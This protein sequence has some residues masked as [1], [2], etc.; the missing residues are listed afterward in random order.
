MSGALY[1][2]SSS[3]GK[4]VVKNL[5]D[6]NVRVTADVTILA[7]H[8]GN[9]G[10]IFR[11]SSAS[12]GADSYNGYYAGIGADGY[13]VLGRADQ[14]W[15]ELKRVSV[16]IAALKAHRISVDAIG[17]QISVTVDNADKPQIQV[18]DGTFA[19]GSAGVRLFNIDTEYGN[20]S[21]APVVAFRRATSTAGYRTVR[22]MSPSRCSRTPALMT[23]RTRPT[24]L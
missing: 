8:E 3:G 11:V 18:R 10:V 21:V 22:A 6:S 1:G 9:A 19:S 17:D 13:I 16:P 5:N 20:F 24:S 14:G 4:A 7:A 12:V 23:F 15:T 2:A